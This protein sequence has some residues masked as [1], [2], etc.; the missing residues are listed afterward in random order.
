MSTVEE[1]ENFTHTALHCPHCHEENPP[2][3]NFC[4]KC[5]TPLWEK[6]LNCGE[7]CVAGENYCGACGTC[8]KEAAVEQAEQIKI[9]FREA[10]RLAAAYRFE[11]AIAL[12]AR[13]GE[14][15]HTRL[16]DFAAR[17]KELIVQLAA[18]RRQQQATAEEAF[19]RAQK[20]FDS[21]DYDAA[22]KSL[23][24]V[25]LPLQDDD[26]LQL[27]SQILER[28]EE[29]SMLVERVQN[30][31]RD[32]RLLDLPQYVEQLLTLKPDHVYAKKVGGQMHKRLLEAA[33]KLFA[34]HQYDKAKNIL[35]QI[36]FFDDTTEFKKLYKQAAETAWLAWDIRKSPVVDSALLGIGERLRRLMPGDAQTAK[37]C[38][39]MGRRVKLNGAKKRLGPA[40]WSSQPQQTSVG[41]P[42]EWLTELRKIVCAEALDRTGLVQHPGRFMVAAGLALAGIKQAALQ[43]NL[44][45][46]KQ[47]NVL[48]RVSHLMRSHHASWGLDLGTSGLKAVKMAWN[49]AKHEEVIEALAFVPHSK[50]LSQAVNEEKEIEIVSQTLRTFL[51]AHKIKTEQV[52]VGLPGRMTFTRQI[53]IPPVNPAKATKLVQFEAVHQFPFPLDKLAWDF[54]VLGNPPAENNGPASTETKSGRALLVAAK[55]PT[56]E[57]FLDAFGRL[58]I[59]VDMLQSDYIALHNF[60]AYDYFGSESDSTTSDPYPVV[61][62]LD[63]GCDATNIVVSSPHSLWFR[64]CGVAGRNF[65]RAIVKEFNLGIDQAEKLKCAPQTAQRLSDLYEALSPVFDDLSHEIQKTL[66]SYAKVHPD[67]SVNRIAGLGGGFALHGL[68]RQLWFGR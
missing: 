12:L 29:I 45:A 61:A 60:L 3:L 16:A 57:H 18:R 20:Y 22:A 25:P 33:K 66:S 8:L 67:R 68:L 7:P 53:K 30:A 65:T 26:M 62:A 48:R 63:I 32:K 41:V 4:A 56:T 34:E 44:L 43:I 2:Q 59:R 64:S 36:A 6:C 37:M 28:R 23:E 14:K 1:T 24:N 42:V 27:G 40:E 38:D 15:D 50:P 10:D 19:K 21:F 5:G 35:E 51:D 49:E 47:K 54:Q 39:E 46:S 13:I 58:G 11:E 17:A 9:D 31:V 52:C 55:A